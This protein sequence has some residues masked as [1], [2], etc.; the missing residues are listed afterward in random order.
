MPGP[1]KSPLL[2]RLWERLASKLGGG[3]FSCEP[4]WAG[5]RDRVKSSISH[6]IMAKLGRIRPSGAGGGGAL[7]GCNPSGAARKVAPRGA[8]VPQGKKFR[9]FGGSFRQARS[10]PSGS[11]RKTLSG[12]DTLACAPKLGVLD[13]HP[14]LQSHRRWVWRIWGGPIPGKT[15]PGKGNTR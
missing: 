9:V 5:M 4:P 13:G 3:G 1:P 12:Q 11:A 15:H 14:W 6:A 7:G 2:A 8:A 10:E